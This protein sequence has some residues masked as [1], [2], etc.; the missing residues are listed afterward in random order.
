MWPSSCLGTNSFHI[1]YQG[2]Q[3]RK[4]ITNAPCNKYYFNV[5]VLIRKTKDLKNIDPYLLSTGWPALTYFALELIYNKRRRWK[6]ITWRKCFTILVFL[7]ALTLVIR[8]TFK[9]SVEVS[10]NILP[11]KCSK[12]TSSSIMC[13]ISSP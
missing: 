12:Y 1:I 4:S 10:K 13:S 9:N 8:L 6:S 7:Y 2:K 5:S 3:V 11:E